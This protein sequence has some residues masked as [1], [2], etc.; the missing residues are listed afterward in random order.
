MPLDCVFVYFLMIDFII[1]M[2]VIELVYLASLVAVIVA[3]LIWLCMG[4][5]PKPKE[6]V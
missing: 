4:S 2:I 1:P 5:T 3:G 6:K